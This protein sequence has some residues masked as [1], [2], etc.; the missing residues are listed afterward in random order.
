MT[1]ATDLTEHLFADWMGRTRLK[2]ETVKL[3]N[4]LGHTVGLH[5]SDTNEL[6]TLC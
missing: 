1:Q 5:A 3:F 2:G 4:R 6:G